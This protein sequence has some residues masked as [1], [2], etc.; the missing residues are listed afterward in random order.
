MSL[1]VDTSFLFAL[2]NSKDRHHAACA[3]TALKVTGR[4][5]V[6]LTVLPEI[7]YL[8]DSRL[9]HHV[10][11]QFVHQITRSVWTLA[12]PDSSDLTRAAAILD[13]YQDSRFDFV[14][15]TLVAIA[16][17]LHIERVLTLDRRHFQLIRPSHCNAF[18]LLPANF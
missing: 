1:L 7:A 5:I 16:E 18:E 10:M 11:R 9:G 15:A 4:L 13:Q 8:L 3:E 2:M 6:P 12:V 14:D 17:R